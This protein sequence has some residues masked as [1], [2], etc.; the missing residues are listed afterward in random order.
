[1]KKYFAAL[2]TTALI[3]SAPYALA[4]SSTDLTVKGTIT[5][6]ACT[7]TLSNGGVI[8]NGKISARDLDP[9]RSTQLK[10]YPLQLT[11]TCDAPI[12]FA[13][14]SIDNKAGTGSTISY[15]G[16]GLTDAGEKL[17]FVY[18]TTKYA[19]AD[20]QEVQ[21]IMSDDSGTS[22][23]RARYID[24]SV[25]VAVGTTADNSIPIAVKDLSMDLEVI[26]FIARA[27]SLTLTDEVTMDGSATFEMKYL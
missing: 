13:L 14:K 2:S 5:P 27:D 15:F 10:T 23:E 6:V 20:G 21:P 4:A 16:L 17:G 19:S 26:T 18:V 7:P 22:W 9:V 1:M 11:V 3:C 25:L 12:V 24:P 8:D